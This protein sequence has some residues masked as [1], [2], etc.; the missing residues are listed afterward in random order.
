MVDVIKRRPGRPR[1]ADSGAQEPAGDVPSDRRMAPS[2]KSLEGAREAARAVQELTPV[3]V[4]RGRPPGPGKLTPERIDA[5]CERI[6]GG[7][8]IAHACY[9]EGV[10]PEALRVRRAMDEDVAYRVGR[11]RAVAVDRMRLEFMELMRAD[12]RAAAILLNY[13]ERADPETYAPPKQ[14]VET[15]G[16]DGGPIQLTAGRVP[17]TEEEALAR[18]AVLQGRLALSAGAA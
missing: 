16:P 10:T 8:A 7:A 4:K 11:A 13:M 9:L 17:L 14:R 2:A 5:I 6:E 18:L 15:S 1:K 12:K 3:P